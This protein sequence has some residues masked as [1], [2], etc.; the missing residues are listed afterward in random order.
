MRRR[1]FNISERSLQCQGFHRGKDFRTETFLWFVEKHDKLHV[2]LTKRQKE[3]KKKKE[4]WWCHA[5]HTT[6]SLIIFTSSITDHCNKQNALRT[7]H[8]S[9]NHI[10]GQYDLSHIISPIWLY[11]LMHILK[12]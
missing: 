3:E 1:L 5:T 2:C 7:E 6:Q 9:F 4:E 10:A 8:D 12:Q 11:D